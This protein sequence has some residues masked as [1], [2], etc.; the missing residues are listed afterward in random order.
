MWVVGNAARLRVADAFCAEAREW[1][2]WCFSLQ[3]QTFTICEHRRLWVG[4]SPQL[5]CRCKFVQMYWRE[6]MMVVTFTVLLWGEQHWINSKNIFQSSFFMKM[7]TVISINIP[8]RYFCQYSFSFK[9]TV[10]LFLCLGCMATSPPS[11]CRGPVSSPGSVCSPE[12]F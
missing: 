7:R 10:Q 11:T 12:F 8:E 3:P 2:L 4:N 1:H 6:V 9:G 5:K